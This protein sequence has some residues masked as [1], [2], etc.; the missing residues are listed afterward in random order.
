MLH[1]RREFFAVTDAGLF[2]WEPGPNRWVSL[3]TDTVSGKK[4]HAVAVD[5]DRTVFLGTENGIFK[6]EGGSAWTAVEPAPRG[7]AGESPFVA[8]ALL[9]TDQHGLFAA[10][11]SGLS[12]GKRQS[13]QTLTWE[14]K[15]RGLPANS[16]VHVL[17]QDPQRPSLLYAGTSRGLFLSQNGGDQWEP[18]RIHGE[19]AGRLD[20]RS[21]VVQQDGT[22]FIGTTDAGVLVGI[23]RLASR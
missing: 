9:W 22:V 5:N 18:A 20:V 6:K 23:N 16:A 7:A 12:L 11:P 15:G 19:D 10:G 13:N 4:I 2:H 8:T 14:T 3:D 17:V 21:V 1:H